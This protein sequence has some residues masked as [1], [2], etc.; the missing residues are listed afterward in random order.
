MGLVWSMK[1]ERLPDRLKDDPSRPF[2]PLE[3]FDILFEVE[4]DGQIVSN[5]RV[6]RL[7]VDPSVV[8]SE[9]REPGL[10]GRLFMP[11]SKEKM[12]AVITLGGSEGG[13]ETAT[14]R[15]MLLASHGYAALAVAYFKFEGLPNELDAIPLETIERA[16][17]YLA[18]RPEV[19]AGRIGIAGSSRGAEMAL[20][21]A[22][23][24]PAIKAVVAYAPNNYSLAAIVRGPQR[25]AWT[26]KGQP[27]PFVPTPS[28]EMV[29][30]FK[31]MSSP[32]DFPPKLAGQ[33]LLWSH[34][35]EKAAIP[36]EKINGA[37]LALISGRDDKL[38]P[39]SEMANLIIARLKEKGFLIQP[40]SLRSKRRGTRSQL[41]SFQRHREFNSAEPR[42]DS[43]RPTPSPG[44]RFLNFLRR[45]FETRETVE[46]EANQ[47]IRV[48][49]KSR[50]TFNCRF[51]RIHLKGH[52][53]QQLMQDSFCRSS[54][55]TPC[56]SKAAKL[57]IR[58]S[59]TN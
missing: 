57:C 23:A 8:I 41:P 1:Q 10:V 49:L 40:I 15:G 58:L 47:L 42:K 6:S 19:D 36:V 17:D 39:S 5:A 53:P 16:R 51:S 50:G 43:P 11:P 2:R 18:K 46:T 34:A 31:Q 4:V 37:V 38:F 28:E 26:L 48:M 25:A 12:A 55:P 33:M 44:S 52:Y 59:L 56:V 35:V 32:T 30:G 45:T 54:L 7:F 27:V 24:F 29:A 13:I 9:V 14:H 21:A 3:T 22:S 20:L